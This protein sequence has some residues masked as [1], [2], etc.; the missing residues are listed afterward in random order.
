[1]FLITKLP[2]LPF[3]ENSLWLR[4]VSVDIID[5]NQY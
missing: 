4:R 5:K 2:L 3:V 1:M